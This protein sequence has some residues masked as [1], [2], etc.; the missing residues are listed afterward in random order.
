MKAIDTISISGRDVLPLVEGGKGIG[1]SDG[2]SSGAW[3]E[4][5]GVGTF[6]AVFADCYDDN[7]DLI[8][9]KFYGKTMRERSKELMQHAIK[10][11]I[12]QAKIA[13]HKAAGNGCIHMNILWGLAN[14]EFIIT[15]ILKKANN[16]IHG[17]VCG[18][19]LPF[20]LAEIAA[21]Y[22][23]YYYPIVSS[24]RTFEILWRRAY[25]RFPNWLGGVVFEDPWKAG[26][27]VGLSSA[28]NPHIPENPYE[29]VKSLRLV[30][31]KYN[32]H[33]IPIIVAGGIWFLSQWQ[34]WINNEELGPIAFQ[35][36]TRPLLTQE[37]PISQEWKKRLLT[38]KKEDIVLNHFSPTGYYSMSIKN[39]FIKQLEKR[40]KRQIA[41]SLE[42][43]DEFST[44][45]NV[46][47]RRIIYIRTSDYYKTQEWL[48][49]GFKK[50]LFT[51]D[52]AIMFLSD[53]EFNN[54]RTDMSNC[55]GC[56][57]GCK[58]SGWIDDEEIAKSIKSIPDPRSYCIRKTLD[59]I[60]HGKS[61]DEN[62]MFAGSNAYLFA[63]DPF[64]ANNFI[65]T[66]KQLIE[67]ILTG[68]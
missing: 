11:G 54:I 43:N 20:K 34:Q 66:V 14:V 40:E 32:L 60:I 42:M 26:G 12:S 62:L 2:Q 56:L 51:P 29:R 63:E 28:E 47:N 53:N 16:L 49:C 23:V 8:P 67:R 5:G 24:S 6:S 9:L 21:K 15:E 57:A 58:F 48:A 13:Y 65:P 61:I 41:Y 30:M 10:A 27:H 17:I 4:S 31:R 19:G 1:V 38:L 33:H 22:S 55:V 46:N 44:R 35:F 50:N 3:A 18:A 59:D 36:G 25:S 39:N 37:S 52:G 68:K 7:G 45:I 64:Y